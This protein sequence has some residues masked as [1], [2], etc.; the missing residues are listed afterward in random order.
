MIGDLVQNG[1]GIVQR[2]RCPRI[3]VP[4]TVQYARRLLEGALEHIP[5][6]NVLKHCVYVFAEVAS[7]LSMSSG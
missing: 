7:Q 1:Q 2:K 4:N 3:A 6:K 5:C